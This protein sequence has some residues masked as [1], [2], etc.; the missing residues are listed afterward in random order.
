[1]KIDEILSEVIKYGYVS[2]VMADTKDAPFTQVSCND[3]AVPIYVI[4]PY[5]LASNLPKDCQVILFSVNGD[6]GNLAGIG[7]VREKRFKNLKEGEVIVGNPI[8]GTYVKFDKDGNVEI[9]S[10]K[11]VTITAATQVKVK[12]DTMVAECTTCTINATTCNINATTTSLG[13]GATE[14]IARSGDPVEVDVGGTPYYGT[15]TGGSSNNKST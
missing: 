1:M 13:V 9:E 7:N 6:A 11:N 3:K 4:N 8:T 12:C 2:Y 15:I 10:K 5:G 14:G